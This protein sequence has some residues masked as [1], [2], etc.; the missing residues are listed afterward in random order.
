MPFS[1]SYAN[2]ILSWAFGKHSALSSHDEVWL[3]LCSNDP[4]A[5]N[6]TFTELSG[7]GYSRVLL[8]QYGKEYPGLFSVASSRVISNIK[9]IGFTKA[10]GGAWTTVKGYGLF[11]DPANGAPYFYAK[12]KEPVDTPEGA[13]FLFDP[14][15]LKVGFHTTDVDIESVT[16]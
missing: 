2:N 6:G 11:V 1:T 12:L 7:K 13:V 16:E 10:T 4:E 9:Q 15:E 5:D 14:G 3:G 8:N